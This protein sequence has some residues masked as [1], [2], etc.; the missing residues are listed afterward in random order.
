MTEKLTE[1][2]VKQI[3]QDYLKQGAFTAR[4]LTDTPTDSLQVVSRKYVTLNGNT[5]NRPKSSVVGQSYYDTQ[6]GKP[7]WWAGSSFKDAAGNI[8]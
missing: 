1:D 3:I 2:R 6:I 5:A 7:V 8:V 4:K